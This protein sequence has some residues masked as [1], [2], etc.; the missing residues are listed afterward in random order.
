MADSVWQGN[1]RPNARSGDVCEG[2]GSW[3]LHELHVA[4]CQ[5]HKHQMEAQFG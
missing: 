5:K 2:R 4:A 1:F 3:L